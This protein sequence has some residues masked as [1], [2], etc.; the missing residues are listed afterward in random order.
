MPV[1]DGYDLIRRV[2]AREVKRG[3]KILPTIA[4][5][6]YARVEDRAR[7]LAA[8]YQMHLAKRVETAQLGPPTV[9]SNYLAETRNT[10]LTQKHAVNLDIALE[11]FDN[12][13]GSPC[14]GCDS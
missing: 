10:P 4:L 13:F 11:P 14:H 8:G 9:D 3:G 2:R 7:A 6:A 5:T 12:C 1:E